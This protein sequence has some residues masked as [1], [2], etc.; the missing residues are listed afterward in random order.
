MKN[1]TIK[2]IKDISIGLDISKASISIYI[3]IKKLDLEIENTISGLKSL[4]SKLKKLYKKEFDNLVFVY[5]PTGS[6]SSLLTKFCSEKE[7]KAFIINP[8]RSHNFAKASGNRN[9]T[10]KLDGRLLSEAI[11]LAKE[12]EIS[13]PVVNLLAQSIKEMMS[14]YKFTVKKRVSVT[15]HLESVIAKDGNSYVLRSLTKEIK[16]LKAKEEEIISKVHSTIFEDKDLREG[17]ENISS[18]IGIGKIGAISLIHLFIKYP[19]AN[20][21]QLTSLVG[22]DPVEFQSGSSINKKAKIS[23]A[24]AKLYRGSLFMGAMT[25]V[26][27]NEELKAFYERLKENGKHTTVAKIAVMRKMII[28]AHSLFKNNQKYS[29]EIY[30]AHCGVVA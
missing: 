28:I 29:S 8:K 12:T 21:R 15:N 14:Y 5:E 17:Y 7:I 26:R 13:V 23:K 22:L 11:I 25:A 30:N 6:Y 2:D 16:D 24:G 20:K 3:P 4:V 9:K 19:D 27:Y 1:S 10:D 18:I